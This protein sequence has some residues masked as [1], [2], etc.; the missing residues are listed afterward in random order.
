MVRVVH[1]YNNKG[2]VQQS[3]NNKYSRPQKK[4]IGFTD[5]PVGRIKCKL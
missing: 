5:D 4:K 2:T 3:K 1:T